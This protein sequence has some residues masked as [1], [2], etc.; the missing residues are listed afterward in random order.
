MVFRR[1]H[2]FAFGANLGLRRQH[3]F[4]PRIWNSI[5]ILD[6]GKRRKYRGDVILCA[7]WGATAWPPW[8]V[9]YSMTGIRVCSNW[10]FMHILVAY[11]ET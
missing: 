9:F 5:E 4:V 10:H 8:L 1:R 3:P 6:R 11:K 7:G 2:E